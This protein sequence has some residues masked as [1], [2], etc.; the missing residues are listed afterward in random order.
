[1]GDV[2]FRPPELALLCFQEALGDLFDRRKL[3]LWTQILLAVALFLFAGL[4]WKDGVNAWILLL[5]TFITGVGAAFATPAWQ[6]IIPRLV[7]RNTLGSAIT[8]NGVSINI[9]RAIGPALGGF[10]L[11]AA[12]A[13]AT[14]LIDAVSYLAVVTALV[15]WHA[16]ATQ[17][18]TLPR[19]RLIG[20]M[21]ASVRFAL[22]STPLRHILL[23]ALA[24]F[25][26]ASMTFCAS[27]S[28]R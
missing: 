14:V 2:G 26:C 22:H 23:R 3:L 19:E 15:W 5:F 20:A 27:T 21:R 10:I 8:L 7:P 13:V 12:G 16:T 6:A 9:A 1:M 18:D 17:A 25:I 28:L 4:L 24:F 11:A